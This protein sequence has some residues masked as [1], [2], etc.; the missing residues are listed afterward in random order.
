MLFCPVLFYGGSREPA[1]HLGQ[2]SILFRSIFLDGLV[3]LWLAGAP[4]LKRLRRKSGGL[5]VES[6]WR[7]G[8]ERI[9]VKHGKVKMRDPPKPC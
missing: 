2:F 9:L 8:V 1:T 6:R 4:S 5:G 7:T 3:R